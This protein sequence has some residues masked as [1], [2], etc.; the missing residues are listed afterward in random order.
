MQFEA[1]REGNGVPS[2]TSL[3]MVGRRFMFWSSCYDLVASNCQGRG[4]GDPSLGKAPRRI[5]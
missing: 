2:V 5:L 4:C 3:E 1:R